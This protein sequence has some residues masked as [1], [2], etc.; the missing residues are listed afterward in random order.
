M[1]RCEQVGLQAVLAASL[2]RIK[3]S[4][5]RCLN[6]RFGF[7]RRVMVMLLLLPAAPAAA[8][9]HPAGGLGHPHQHKLDIVARAHPNPTKWP[10]DEVTPAAPAPE[11]CQVESTVDPAAFGGAPAAC[12]AEPAAAGAEPAAPVAA[13]V[14][15]APLSAGEVE[16]SFICACCCFHSVLHPWG[17]GAARLMSA[18]S[19]AKLVTGDVLSLRQLRADCLHKC[20]MCCTER[21]TCS[22]GSVANHTAAWHVSPGHLHHTHSHARM[23]H[24]ADFL[25]CAF[26]HLPM[27]R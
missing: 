6:L 16:A 17:E 2:L 15:A 12:A 18:C 25:P 10:Q 9:R 1:R 23:P 24:C 14:P 4:G 5:F 26:Q 21:M 8:G 19:H 3:L 13:A 20:T 27:C 11:D 22:C 7:D